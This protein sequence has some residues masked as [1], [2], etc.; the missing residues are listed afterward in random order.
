MIRATWCGEHMI[1]GKEPCLFPSH[2]GVESLGQNI[3]QVEFHGS[4][5][6]YYIIEMSHHL[7]VSRYQLH[8]QE[9]VM[10]GKNCLMLRGEKAY[11][12]RLSVV[13]FVIY[14]SLMGFF[15]RTY[16]RTFGQVHHMDQSLF[17]RSRKP[18]HKWAQGGW[19]T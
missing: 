15:R 17:D 12:I 9:G 10:V 7:A 3:R 18:E 8:V 6:K 13:D 14:M 2:H 19:V 11:D 4:F 5:S 1:N 16:S